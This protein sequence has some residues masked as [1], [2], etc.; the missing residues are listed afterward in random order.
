MNKPGRYPKNRYGNLAVLI[1][2][3]GEGEFT[4]VL[5]SERK[6]LDQL[7]HSSSWDSAFRSFATIWARANFIEV[8][9]KTP[10]DLLEVAA[11]I[12]EALPRISAE[13]ADQAPLV[14]LLSKHTVHPDI[15]SQMLFA[16]I[17]VPI[18]PELLNAATEARNNQ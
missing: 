14:A 16:L 7:F 11:A 17:T 8:A 10:L 6:T 1:A 4:P 9:E 13:R 5:Q 3:L 18:I 2:K 15:E 12:G